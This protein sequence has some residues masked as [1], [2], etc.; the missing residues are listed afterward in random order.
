MSRSAKQVQ[1][2]REAG[3][4]PV[5]E[6]EKQ[7]RMVQDALMDLNRQKLELS[8]QVEQLKA[9]REGRKSQGKQG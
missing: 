7:A 4:A 6:T 9:K 3:S 8:A 5:D 1:D 2:I